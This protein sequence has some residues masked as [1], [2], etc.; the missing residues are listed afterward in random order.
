MKMYIDNL[1]TYGYALKMSH[2]RISAITN[3]CYLLIALVYLGTGV[4]FGQVTQAPSQTTRDHVN[5]IRDQR[6]L[7][8]LSNVVSA[9]HMSNAPEVTSAIVIANDRDGRVAT[10]SKS[11]EKT[12]LDWDNS[13]TVK[14]LIDDPSL[15]D[16]EQIGRA[17][18]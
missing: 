6:S 9:L 5:A 17:H 7:G 2:P 16:E 8:I 10:W 1:S 12:R 4:I 18:V 11:K 3:C 14:T 15:K 13:G